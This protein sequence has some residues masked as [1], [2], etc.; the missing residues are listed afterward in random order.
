[1]FEKVQKSLKMF[2]N[3]YMAKKKANNPKSYELAPFLYRVSQ[4]LHLSV[5]GFVFGYFVVS[6]FHFSIFF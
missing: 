1:M 3:L 6:F 2:K 5:I 4:Q